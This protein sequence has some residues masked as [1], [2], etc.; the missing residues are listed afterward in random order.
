M[1][2][3]CSQA[4]GRVSWSFS[5]LQKWYSMPI[6]QSPLS[7]STSH[8][9]FENSRKGSIGFIPLVTETD[10]A[11]LWLSIGDCKLFHY[12]RNVKKRLACVSRIAYVE[13]RKL[14]VRG[15]WASTTLKQARTED[16]HCFRTP[17][18]YRKGLSWGT[19][20]RLYMTPGLVAILGCLKDL[21]CR[22]TRANV[23]SRAKWLWPV[24]DG[25]K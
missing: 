16:M 14:G 19:P 17:M 2:C 22:M 1:V 23:L 20:L 9:Y 4:G 11:S 7:L 6:S 24:S 15:T 25:C 3:S 8:N 13:T 12:L 5:S 18:K 10:A 21:E